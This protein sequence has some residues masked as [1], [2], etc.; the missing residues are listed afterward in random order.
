MRVLVLRRLATVVVLMGI[1]LALV[2]FGLMVAGAEM[3]RAALGVSPDADLAAPVVV[4][5]VGAEAVI[6]AFVVGLRART[7]Q[8]D[9]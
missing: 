7:T 3:A 5:L 4:G 6:A 2:A 8:K 9:G 1:G